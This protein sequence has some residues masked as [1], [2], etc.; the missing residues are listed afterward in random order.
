MALSIEDVPFQLCASDVVKHV[1]NIDSR[2]RENPTSST[3]SDFYFRLLSPIRNVLRIR[4]TSSEMPNNYYMFSTKRRN[5]K[6]AIR[7][8]PSNISSVVITIPGGNYSAYQMRDALNAAFTAAGLSWLTS[9]FNV[10]TGLFTFTGSGTNTFVIDTIV[11]N[12]TD[13]TYDRPFDYGLGY[14]LGFSRG[15]FA[16]TSNG[17]NNI[18]ISNQYAFFAGDTYMLLKVNDFDCVRQTITGSDIAALAKIVISQP[19]NFMTYD[20]Y[21]NQQAKEVTFPAPHDLSRF[22]IQLL[23]PYGYPID[24]SSS[25]FSFSIEVLEIRKLSLYNT[26]RNAFTVG[27]LLPPPLRSGTTGL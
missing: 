21:A 1:I 7:Y 18:V 11:A 13:S 23:D 3:S 26:I 10:V 17:T 5:V 8:G 20:G 16:S 25:Q 2:F 15:T 6:I 24:M 19:K 12:D 9:A 4:I 27:W 14:N 22:H